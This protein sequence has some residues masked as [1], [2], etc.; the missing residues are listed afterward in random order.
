MGYRQWKERVTALSPPRE[1]VRG[2]RTGKKE[3][4][5]LPLPPLCAIFAQVNNLIKSGTDE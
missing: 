1:L 5:I 2:R 4:I 3:Q